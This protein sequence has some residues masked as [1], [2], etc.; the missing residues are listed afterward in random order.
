M[1]I[2]PATTT[3]PPIKVDAPDFLPI[4][5]VSA[6]K[7]IQQGT[8]RRSSG[9]AYVQGSGDDHELW[10]MVRSVSSI[11]RY[12]FNYF[13]QGLTSQLFWE[14]HQDLIAADRSQ[15]SSL[16]S[17]I[18]STP[19]SASN[20]N[21]TTTSMTPINRVGG[22]LLIGS[23]ADVSNI[24]NI[25]M[26]DNMEFIILTSS[27]LQDEPVSKS[28]KIYIP[29]VSGKIGQSY[30]L[31]TILP[32]T[33]ELIRESLTEGKRV[34]IACESGKDLSVGVA[35]AA[36]QLFFQDNGHLTPMD[37]V[38]T[39]SQGAFYFDLPAQSHGLTRS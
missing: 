28:Q 15:L 30:F 18:I 29:A 5:C 37:P 19:P 2:T 39:L 21:K 6:S 4:V 31:R 7:Q 14:H 11:A 13:A 23:I 36:L 1:W 3:F 24:V 17:K 32:T 8:E 16:V 20:S 35:L 10:G 27:M 25:N 38:S 22:R 9:F 12:C 26:E 33:T 34:C